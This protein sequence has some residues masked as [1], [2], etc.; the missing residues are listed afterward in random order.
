[1]PLQRRNTEIQ[2]KEELS[3][4]CVWGVFGVHVEG[5]WKGIKVGAGN[6]ICGSE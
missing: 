2:R 4:G 6:W 3:Q 1:M 5:E